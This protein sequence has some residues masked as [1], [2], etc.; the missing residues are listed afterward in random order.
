MKLLRLS[1]FLLILFSFF[2]PVHAD[3]NREQAKFD[4]HWMEKLKNGT[5]EEKKSAAVILGERK[6]KRAVDLMI[7]TLGNSKEDLEVRVQMIYGLVQTEDRKALRRVLWTLNSSNNKMLRV[8]AVRSLGQS[9]NPRFLQPLLRAL[10]RDQEALVKVAVIKVLPHFEDPLATNA[11]MQQLKP[12]VPDQLQNAAIQSLSTL[13]PQESSRALMDLYHQTDTMNQKISILRA[14][15]KIGN[16][17]IAPDLLAIV[18]DSNNT[19]LRAYAIEAIGNLRISKYAGVIRSSLNEKKPPIQHACAIALVQLNEKE[20]VHTLKKTYENLEAEYIAYD[21]SDSSEK[22]LNQIAQNLEAREAI[23]EALVQ[24]GPEKSTIVFRNALKRPRYPNQLTLLVE[25]IRKQAIE[26]LNKANDITSTDEITRNVLLQ[27]PDLTLRRLAVEALNHL[28]GEV[29]YQALIQQLENGV[30]D[31][32]RANAAYALG[33]FHDEALIEPLTLALNDRSEL[34]TKEA[35]LALAET[36]GVVDPERIQSVMN[37]S[38]NEE[39]K[40]VSKA[41]LNTLNHSFRVYNGMNLQIRYGNR[42]F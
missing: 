6:V 25:K 9:G 23:L 24:L 2:G 29:Q 32:E 31:Q 35:L 22:N 18:E 39:L 42:H 17:Q 12:S 36:P 16:T 30:T 41:V 40:E 37:G 27:A 38:D 20:S 21:M 19:P 10:K 15:G 26:G 11:L 1:V 14:V 28:S 13:K 34:V 3:R 7:K 5:E 33:G 8:A 4:Y